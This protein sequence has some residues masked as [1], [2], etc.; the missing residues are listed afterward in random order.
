MNNQIKDLISSGNKVREGAGQKFNNQSDV[1]LLALTRSI[2][3]F[4]KSSMK[5]LDQFI[6][7]VAITDKVS[8]CLTVKDVLDDIYILLGDIIPYDRIGFALIDE[9][10]RDIIRSCWV[11]S[12][13]NNIKIQEGYEASFKS[14]SLKDIFESGQ[15]QDF[16]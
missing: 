8:E 4:H 1:N 9:K 5:H 13:S 3:N 14:S 6:K 11:H 15:P 10:N 12:E 7:S 16:E 2:L